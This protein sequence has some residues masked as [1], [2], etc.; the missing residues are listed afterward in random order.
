MKY[1]ILLIIIVGY[2]ISACK[3][4][5][6]PL[7]IY[8]FPQIENGDTIHHK[9]PPFNFINQDSIAV[10]NASLE[11]NIYIS[12]FFFI[13]CPSIC[14]KVKKEM[15][16][17]YDA[18]EDEPLVKFVSHTM[19]T[20]YDTIPALKKYANA[21]GV[22]HDKWYFVTG[23]KEE[24]H[25]I[26][27]DYFNVVIEDKNAPGGYDHSGKLILTDKD[28]HIRAFSEGTDPESTPGFI[29]NIAKLVDEY[30]NPSS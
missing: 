25:D 2:S 24:I 27:D 10:T 26:A 14:P 13:S 21:L 4:K 3:Q 7:P 23:V 5:D 18:F 15:L 6:G 12:D 20:K 19:D 11:N 1:L 17:I 16:K 8:G 29:K 22:S 30:S 9:I 28:G